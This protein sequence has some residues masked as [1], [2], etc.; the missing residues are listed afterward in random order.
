MEGKT[1][2]MVNNI[3]NYTHY[4]YINPHTYHIHIT[5]HNEILYYRRTQNANIDGDPSVRNAEPKYLLKDIDIHILIC[6]NIF[7]SSCIII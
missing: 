1:D 7:S 3:L 5:T 4:P 6:C 2:D